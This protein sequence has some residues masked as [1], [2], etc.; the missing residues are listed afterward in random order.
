M[1]IRTCPL[2]SKNTEISLK[3]TKLQEGFLAETD[4]IRF[5]AL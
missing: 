2:Q 4:N 3:R 5:I 1:G